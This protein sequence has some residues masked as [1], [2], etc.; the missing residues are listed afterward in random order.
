MV[1]VV[2][3]LPA[4]AGVVRDEGFG[5]IPGVGN[6]KPLQYSC[7]ENPMD[8]EAWWPTVHRVTK[9]RTR[10][11]S[12][13][14]DVVSKFGNCWVKGCAVDFLNVGVLTSLMHGADLHGY[15]K[16][17]ALA[18]ASGLSSACSAVDQCVHHCFSPSL[19]FT[20]TSHCLRCQ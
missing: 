3:K 10:L 11:S 2:R 13:T 5:K 9:N 8:R 1:L 16:S 18:L 4:N 7:L 12:L 6:G 19:P 14:R 17:P 15:R 20:K